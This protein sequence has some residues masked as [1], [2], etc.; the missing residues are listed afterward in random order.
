MSAS[1]LASKDKSTPESPESLLLPDDRLPLLNLPN[2]AFG[3]AWS[4]H[5][6]VLDEDEMIDG[7][8]SET[9]RGDGARGLYMAGERL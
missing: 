9:R 4:L 7:L 8:P 2:R 3:S 1:F 6:Y 5:E